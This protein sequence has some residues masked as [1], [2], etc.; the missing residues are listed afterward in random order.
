MSHSKHRSLNTSLAIKRKP[1]VNTIAQSCTPD[2]CW[3]SVRTIVS[4]TPQLLSEQLRSH[5][6]V[7]S[8]QS[9]AG[10]LLGGVWPWIYPVNNCFSWKVSPPAEHNWH[11]ERLMHPAETF[12]RSVHEASWASRGRRCQVSA[13]VQWGI[14][15]RARWDHHERWKP[16]EYGPPSQLQIL[17]VKS[18]LAYLVFWRLSTCLACSG[19]L[20]TSACLFLMP[21]NLHMHRKERHI[22]VSSLARQDRFLNAMI[23]TRLQRSTNN[24]R[25]LPNSTT[26]SHS[27]LVHHIMPRNVLVLGI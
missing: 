17:K 7:E 4:S 25:S 16:V 9:K 13:E 6:C 14:L 5:Q 21:S 11:G 22:C 10:L 27:I 12:E 8:I 3:H 1:F 15:G 2:A 18:R 26:R 19:V 20:R 23:I 24:L